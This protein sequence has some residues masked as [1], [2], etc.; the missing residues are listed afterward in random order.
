[1][2]RICNIPPTCSVQSTEI[3]I[4]SV[5]LDT[6][7]QNYFETRDLTTHGR[8]GGV[9]SGII[10]QIESPASLV[11]SRTGWPNS[12]VARTSAINL[13]VAFR[14]QILNWPGG[15]G[16]ESGRLHEMRS[17]ASDSSECRRPETRRASSRKQEL[18]VGR[19]GAGSI[20]TLSSAN[21][22]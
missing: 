15:C 10:D 2:W 11:Q 7:R 17:S 9:A 14:A 21:K 16:R 13:I 4:W 1:L 20:A 19:R 5:S 18:C 12:D 6:R 8:Q 3:S 22:S